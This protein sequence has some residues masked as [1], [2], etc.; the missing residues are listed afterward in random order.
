MTS[1]RTLKGVARPAFKIATRVTSV[2]AIICSVVFTW[3]GPA[4]A[5]ST[6]KTP[7]ASVA[8]S[9]EDAASKYFGDVELIDQD[10]RPQR[11]YSDLFKGKVVIINP[12]FTTC[13]GVCPPMTR[14]LEAIQDW[15]G[16][17]LG[18]EVHM[19]SITV[20]P[21]TD[22]PLKLKQ[23]AAQFHAKPGWYFVGGTRENTEM[24][25]RKLGQYVQE[26]SDHSTLM[27]VG[28]LRTGLWKKALAMARPADLIAIVESV[29]N[30]KPP[31]E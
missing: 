2:L 10:G 24:A 16:S 27:I 14:N 7:A 1:P 31:K 28:N 21:E 22:T 8:A 19:I 9:P 23:Y 17:R 25:L 11:L 3:P 15:L 20:D 13:T 18:K 6:E 5:Q 26:K 29:V 4:S 12:F 30:D